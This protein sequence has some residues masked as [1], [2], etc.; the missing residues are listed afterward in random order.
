MSYF[1]DIECTRLTHRLVTLSKP[2]AN[3]SFFKDKLD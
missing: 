2:T 1:T 3:A